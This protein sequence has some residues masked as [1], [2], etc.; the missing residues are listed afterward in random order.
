MNK[1]SPS[2][3]YFACLIL[4]VSGMWVFAQ[5]EFKTDDMDPKIH[6]SAERMK[7]TGSS[8]EIIENFAEIK[9]GSERGKQML[10]VLIHI[11]NRS[12]L[13][14]ELL[15]KFFSL[16]GSEM[17][18]DMGYV[19]LLTRIY[20]QTIL[21]PRVL[22]PQEVTLPDDV[23]QTRIIPVMAGILNVE[24]SDYWLF[25]EGPV[26]TLKRLL[27]SALE[28]DGVTEG[29]KKAAAESLDMVKNLMK[30]DKAVGVDH[31]NDLPDPVHP[32]MT[33]STTDSVHY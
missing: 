26:D 12:D 29:A 23:L 27:N 15:S 11:G 25:N 30:S 1:K 17:S 3:V 10:L 8:V 32:S 2:S 13:K 24:Q 14:L 7:T 28:R 21:E 18:V 4:L 5:A 20:I 6:Q 31:K 16:P 9:D 19:Q 22:T 33:P